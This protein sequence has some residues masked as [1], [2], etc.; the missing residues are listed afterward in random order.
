MT[1]CLNS[2]AGKP[3]CAFCKSRACAACA[4][5]PCRIRFIERLIGTVRREYLDQM[6]FWNRADLEQKLEDFQGYYNQFRVHQSLEGETPVG[7]A[8]GPTAEPARLE[9]YRWQSHCHGLFE[10]PIA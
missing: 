1:R 3:T 8:G 6:F 7:K 10:L 4:T 2:I 9:H 5:R